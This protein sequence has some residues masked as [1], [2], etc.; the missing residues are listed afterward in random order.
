MNNLTNE[1]CGEPEH[2]PTTESFS[3]EKVDQLLKHLDE[4]THL[5]VSNDKLCAYTDDKPFVKPVW[6]TFDHKTVLNPSKL[7]ISKDQ[8]RGYIKN[9]MDKSLELCGIN[10]VNRN[11]TPWLKNV[12]DPRVLPSDQ[13]FEVKPSRIGEIY[14]GPN[15]KEYG[16]CLAGGFMS[17]FVTGNLI[18]DFDLFPVGPY[19]DNELIQNVCDFVRALVHDNCKAPRSTVVQV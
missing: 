2:L 18:K 16:F 13:S 15:L 3:F 6:R 4:S 1:T 7:D 11:Y 5:G 19:T 10:G 8:A 14:D 12:R 9:F 17:S